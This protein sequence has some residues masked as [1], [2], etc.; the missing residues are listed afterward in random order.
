M[1]GALS[2]DGIAIISP[3]IFT[4]ICGGHDVGWF[5][6]QVDLSDISRG[7]AWGHLTGESLPADTFLNKLTKQEFR[8]LLGKTFDIIF[9]ENLLGDI[10]RRHLTEERNEALLEFGEEE[11]F[12]NKTRFFLRKKRISL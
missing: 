12:S 3:M 9:E 6:H 7:P 1:A 2:D 4:G 10:G 11:L 5:P 8:D